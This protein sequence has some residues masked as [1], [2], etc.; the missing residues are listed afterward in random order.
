MRFAAVPVT[1]RT[2]ICVY[3]SGWARRTRFNISKCV[4]RAVVPRD[5]VMCRWI[6]WWPSKKG[7]AKKSSR[8]SIVL[9]DRMK[10]LYL[11]PAMIAKRLTPLILLALSWNANAVAQQE[12]DSLSAARSLLQQGRNGEAIAQLKVLSARRPQ[13]KGVKYLQ[14]AWNEDPKDR[15]AAQLLGLSYY[16]TGRPTDAIP[17]LEKVRTWYPD[18]NIDALYILGLCYVMTKRYPEALRTFAQL[19]GVKADSAAAHLLLG[20]MLLRQGFDPVAESEIQSALLISPQLPLAH[21]ALGEL[22]VYG[23]NY[24]KAVQE[25]KAELVLNPAC[26]VALTHLGEMHWRLSRDEDAQKV[27]RRSIS[28]DSTASEPHVVLG[29]VLLR[30][31]Q[32]ALAEKN[33]RDAIHLDPSSYTAHY[34]LGQLYRSEG[35]MEAAEQELKAAARIQQLQTSSPARN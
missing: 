31:G 17:A 23:G 14:D 22:S 9:N 20:R 27:L 35:R 6:A 13:V 10:R 30:E 5:S 28:L 21:F 12:E 32:T 33:L 3:I 11:Q 15:D 26:A 25:F 4:G 1:F 34:F 2:A 7:W 24:P 16:S 8:S 19:Y 18:A 29:K